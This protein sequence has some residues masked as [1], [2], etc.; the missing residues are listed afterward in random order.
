MA[1]RRL[2]LAARVA[3]ATL[4]GWLA[5]AAVLVV[6]GRI[7]AVVAR[8]ALPS[9]AGD[10]PRGPRPGRR[11]A[12]ARV[13]RD[14][15]PHALSRR[16]STTARS[17]APNRSS[18]CSSGPRRTCARLL[19][20]GATTARD[21]GSRDDVALAIRS[22]IRDGRRRRA[23]PARRRCADHHD[24][25]PLLVPRRRGRH[26][27]RGHPAGARAPEARCR[28][29]E[30]HGVGRR[31]HA[32]VEPALAAVRRSRRCGPPSTRRTGWGCRS[33]PTR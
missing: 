32:D 17:P 12:A 31:L 6:D 3:D 28:L 24:R 14:P 18:G 9:D 4:D 19:L 33:W 13:R 11:L 30:D 16:R 22:A 26:D 7:E 20:S 27:R 1:T 2:F 23:A 29:R 25:R 5:D 15:H 8:A 10:D 21:T